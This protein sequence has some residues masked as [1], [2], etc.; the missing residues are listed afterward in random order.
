MSEILLTVQ[1]LGKSIA[2]K[3]LF[4]NVRFGISKQQRI[5]LIGDNGT[6]KST[7]LR[8]LANEL[9]ADEGK[10]MYGQAC[11]L[12]YLPQRPNL[13]IGT[14][15]EALNSP[16]AALQQQI[17]LYQ[18]STDPAQQARCMEQIELLGGWHW[19]HHVERAAQYFGI[20]ELEQQV[21]TLSG[22]QQKRVA[23]AKLMLERPDLVLLDE[24]TNH[25][26]TQTIERLEQWLSDAQVAALL[27]THDRYFLD[28][29][30]EEMLE[31]RD[32]TCKRYGGGY[33]GYLAARAT[34]EQLAERSR[35]RQQ[36]LAKVELAWLSRSPQARTTK[37][38][39]RV[40][41]AEALQEAVRL[42][43]DPTAS[44]QFDLG[45]SPR[46]GKTILQLQAIC[47]SV[48]E[49]QLCQPFSLTLQAGQRWGIL[50]PN[51][52]GKTTLLKAILGKHAIAAGTIVHGKN[53]VVGSIDQQRSML[54]PT[55]SVRQ[56]LLPLGG[57]YV[58]FATK[59]LHI[60]QWLSQF[61]FGTD[62]L[63]MRVGKM[64]GGEQYR[65]VLAKTFQQPLNVLLLDEPTNDLDIWTMA[66][67]EQALLAFTGCVLVVSH[68]RYFLN[69]IAT[70]ILAFAEQPNG[71]ACIT[72]HIGNYS[73]WLAQ[74]QQ[75]ARVEK[76]APN[77]GQTPQESKPSSRR[78]GLSFAK[79]HQ[80]GKLETT[81]AAKEELQQRL[82][83]ELADP[84][85]WQGQA[86]AGEQLSLRFQAVQEELQQLYQNWEQLQ[87]DDGS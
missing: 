6:G 18:T 50:G 67:L 30:V 4:T 23:L 24:P 62:V 46:L 79:A 85:I 32:G 25:L 56:L 27:V 44:M 66:L 80:L 26:D 72:A 83:Q 82:E 35:A 33:A 73:D 57:D 75:Q 43:H 77:G 38:R 74:Q 7:L 49:R 3:C 78:P 34:Q 55:Q 41:R 58:H 36:Q 42:E 12:A 19:Q 11:R 9:A 48:G 76:T 29:I 1:Q 69:K 39:A 20:Q 45:Q 17:Q 68:D 40:E 15:Q 63:G 22:G 54:D 13:A 52:I 71:P 21:A 53:N 81:I 8:I 28:S 64:S 87:C 5:G 16:F 60:Q 70:G 14:V 86:G 59:S 37:S 65:L 2:D 51:G 47:L 10:V 31:L 61:G 84:A